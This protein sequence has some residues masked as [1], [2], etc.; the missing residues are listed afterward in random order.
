MS[1]SPSINASG[2]IEWV[3]K[4]SSPDGDNLIISLKFDAVDSGS[5]FVQEN[6][7]SSNVS[8]LNFSTSSNI[9]SDGSRDV[10]STVEVDPDEI[11]TGKS[12]RF[13]F[14]AD[15]GI[16]VSI[17]TS[18]LSVVKATKFDGTKMYQTD[19]AVDELYEYD[20]SFSWD[21]SSKSLTNSENTEG[22]YVSGLFFKDDG[23]KMYQVSNDGYI[24]EIDLATPWDIS[25]TSL[26]QTVNSADSTPKQ[27]YFR[28]DG[29]KMYEIAGGSYKIYEYNL[30][31]AWDVSTASV[32][33][34]IS[35]QDNDPTS[36]FL[37]RDGK[38]MYTSDEST[39]NIYEYDLV[40]AW[41][42]SAASLSFS[43]NA[44]A[45][46]PEG[47]FFRSDGKKFFEYNEASGKI[48]EYD[49]STAWNISTAS[50]NQSIDNEN[51]SNAAGT[52]F[53]GKA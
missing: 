9:N 22:I 44:Q 40:T 20:L 1:R 25:V 49:L 43:I 18:V 24:Y 21:I 11:Y 8:W 27:V 5:G 33:Q 39:A 23:S 14:I 26:N 29:L 48:Y 52:V 42:L 13:K 46:S 16:N 53:F 32:N 3:E 4:A 38:K 34:S 35:T 2:N 30:S 12:Y 19:G 28:S 36:I 37:K 45:S 6:K 17:Q 10:N 31:T 47:I 15:D 51:T 50:V 41:D 7:D